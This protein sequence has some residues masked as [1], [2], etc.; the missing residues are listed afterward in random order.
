MKNKIKKIF[1]TLLKKIY[2]T[3]KFDKLRRYPCIEK[4]RA[5]E[6]FK[7]ANEKGIRYVLLRWEQTLDNPSEVEDFDI[8]VDNNDYK[9]MLK[10][11]KF[12]KPGKKYA[13]VDLYTPTHIKSDI[14][15][16][17]PKLSNSILQ[18]RIKNKNDVFIPDNLRHFLSFTYHL[19]FH[20]GYDSGI[21]SKNNMI[22][23]EI[24][25]YNINQN[26]YIQELRR[27]AIKAKVDL[28][29]PVFLEYLEDLLKE[30]D[31][32]PPMDLYFRRSKGNKY[33]LDRL[34]DFIPSAWYENYNTAVVLLRDIAKE[35]CTIEFFKKIL[36]EQDV[37]IEQE[38][39]LSI[40]QGT[41][42]AEV[43]RGGDWNLSSDFSNDYLPKYVY[44][45]KMKKEQNK[46]DIIPHGVVCYDWLLSVKREVRSYFHKKNKGEYIHILHSSDNGVE[47]N[48]Y[49]TELRKILEN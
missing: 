11:C 38:I 4:M 48:Y 9:K 47:A 23:V 46:K 33:L 25:N 3:F 36:A 34:I 16:I 24:D 44:Y 32:N 6:F 17:L 5:I 2:Y 15:Y 8:L 30:Y 13:S 41:K 21:M 43:T 7:M 12:R 49:K 42:V 10:L 26:K 20:K 37:I 40:E 19:V 35:H 31:W 14:A 28:K 1:R 29:Y 45:L 22:N 39:E 27:L 18:N